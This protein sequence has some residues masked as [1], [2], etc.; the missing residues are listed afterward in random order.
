MFI[1]NNQL[2]YRTDRKPRGK[3]ARVCRSLTG[4]WQCKPWHSPKVF[5]KRLNWFVRRDKDYFNIVLFTDTVE[6]LEDWSKCLAWGT[7]KEA[8]R[9]HSVQYNYASGNDNAVCV[10]W[11]TTKLK[12]RR[13][14]NPFLSNHLLWK[15]LHLAQQVERY[16]VVDPSK[17]NSFYVLYSQFECGR[18]SENLR[19]TQHPLF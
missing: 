14:P 6:V 10:D 17:S 5:L 19:S 3:I 4:H 7:P 11:L 9:R 13:A 16:R 8:E 18:I 1:E 12:S 15:L 2:G